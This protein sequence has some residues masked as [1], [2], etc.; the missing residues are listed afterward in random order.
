MF[1][2]SKTL[3]GLGSLLRNSQLLSRMLAA[4]TNWQVQ[5][6]HHAE[7]WGAMAAGRPVVPPPTRLPDPLANPVPAFEVSVRVA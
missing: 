6:L 1:K 5:A 7:R 3:R 4:E 2:L